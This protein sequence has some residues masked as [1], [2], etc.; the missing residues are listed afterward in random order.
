MLTAGGPAFTQVPTDRLRHFF[1]M[2]LEV[3]FAPTGFPQ[4]GPSLL[5]AALCTALSSFLKLLDSIAAGDSKEVMIKSLRAG[6]TPH[7]FPPP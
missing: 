4:D 2:G 1:E 5:S 7:I 6:T 3:D